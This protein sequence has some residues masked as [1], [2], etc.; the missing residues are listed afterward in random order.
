[1]TKTS[2]NV[3]LGPHSQSIEFTESASI[4]SHADDLSTWENNRPAVEVTF[5]V[6]MKIILAKEHNSDGGAGGEGSD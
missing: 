6:Y 2:S 3:L 1:M 5:L 4:Y